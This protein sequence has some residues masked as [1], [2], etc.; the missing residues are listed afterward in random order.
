M[1]KGVK[2]KISNNEAIYPC[3][4]YPVGSVYISFVNTN[5]STYFGGTWEQIKDRFLIG[6]GNKYSPGSTGGS[7]THSHALSRKGGANMR[8]YANTFYQGEYT[9]AGTMPKQSD[10]GTWWLTTAN[11]DSS[12][13]S[14]PGVK[15][16]GI[17][18]YGSTD[19]KNVLPPYIAVYL[20]RRVA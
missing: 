15:G 8:K 3:P 14:D 18:L 5:P 10:G 13:T 2:F 6:A 1:S 17:G 7:E 11:A 12:S 19:D 20:W 9:T 16:V 4:F